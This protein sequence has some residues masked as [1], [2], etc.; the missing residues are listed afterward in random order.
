MASFIQICTVKDTLIN[1]VTKFARICHTL[2]PTWAKF[3]AQ[4]VYKNVLSD[5]E[6]RENRP[7]ENHALFNGVDEFVSLLSTFIAR[8]G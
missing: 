8:F 3:G 4:D 1:D 2:R 5:L 7:N 6:F